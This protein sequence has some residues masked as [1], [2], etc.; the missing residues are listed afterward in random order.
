MPSSSDIHRV[1]RV[2]VREVFLALLNKPATSV[3]IQSINRRLHGWP[4]DRSREVSEV[5]EEPIPLRLHLGFSLYT[6]LAQIG[7]MANN[8]VSLDN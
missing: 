4:Y 6:F 1:I 2:P 8:L 3:L 5:C 7:P